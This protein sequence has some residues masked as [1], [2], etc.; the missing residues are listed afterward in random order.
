MGLLQ[1]SCA[2]SEWE[3]VHQAVPELGLCRATLCTALVNLRQSRI[4]GTGAPK[5][6]LHRASWGLQG[7]FAWTPH[8]VKVAT[9][10]KSKA[11]PGSSITTVFMQCSYVSASVTLLI[12]NPGAIAL[13]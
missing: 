4:G 10:L 7:S 6:D 11:D 3:L 1:Y 13:G 8:Q 9:L 12:T 5:A 2:C